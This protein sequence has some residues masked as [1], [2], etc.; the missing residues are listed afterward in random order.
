[1]LPEADAYQESLRSTRSSL[2]SRRQG[3]EEVCPEAL[4]GAAES[5]T[6]LRLFLHGRAAELSGDHSDSVWRRATRGEYTFDGADLW[7][8]V[9]Q[10]PAAAQ[11]YLAPLVDALGC[12]LVP[13]EGSAA[14]RN[15]ALEA[16]QACRATAELAEEIAGALAVDGVDESEL[17]SL[18]AKVSTSIR[19]VVDVGTSLRRLKKQLAERKK[20][21]RSR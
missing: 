14:S 13:V 1:V 10:D 9:R 7:R 11:V 18:L 6:D 12:A 20:A 2:R 4:D 15:V 8:L 17:R 21:E 5:L 19:E 16:A 3:L